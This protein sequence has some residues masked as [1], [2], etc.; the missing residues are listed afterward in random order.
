M[1]FILGREATERWSGITL[2]EAQE[3]VKATGDLSVILEIIENRILGR[4]VELR[5]ALTA[6][7]F[8]FM[9]M[10]EEARFTTAEVGA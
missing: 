6:D 9:L 7:E 8:G 10:A 5:G 3:K 2:A 4:C 1:I